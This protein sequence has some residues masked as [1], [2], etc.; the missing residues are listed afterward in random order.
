M[1]CVLPISFRADWSTWSMRLP[2]VKV[3]SQRLTK[4]FVLIKGLI[5]LSHQLLMSYSGALCYI[6]S[7]IYS[8]V[9][10]WNSTQ[11]PCILWEAQRGQQEIPLKNWGFS[12]L[13]ASPAYTSTEWTKRVANP[14][15]LYFLLIT[16]YVYLLSSKHMRVLSPLCY[17]STGFKYR[18]MVQ[19]HV[20]SRPLKGKWLSS[21]EGRGTRL[22]GRWS[23]HFPEI[24]LC[25]FIKSKLSLFQVVPSGHFASLFQRG[26][27]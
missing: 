11:L 12:L 4:P 21:V 14:L 17:N 7:K 27:K 22:S 2:M 5:G 6:D 9:I 3:C 20:E 24:I 19:V 10:P 23:Y 18:L 13:V 25:L 15:P 16:E 1:C 26:R 8:K